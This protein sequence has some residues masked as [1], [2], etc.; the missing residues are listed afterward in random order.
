MISSTCQSIHYDTSQ[1]RECPSLTPF[2]PP[3]PS[4]WLPTDGRVEK[5]GGGEQTDTHKGTL[6][7]YIVEHSRLLSL[8]RIGST[9]IRG[10]AEEV[11]ERGRDG[12]G[13]GLGEVETGGRKL[14]EEGRSEEGTERDKDWVR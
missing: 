8:D 12:M 1:Y 4:P 9:S 2:L 6:Q 14:A 5:G 11:N 10:R 7:L 3:L 13:Q